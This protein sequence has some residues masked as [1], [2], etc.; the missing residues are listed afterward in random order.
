MNDMEEEFDPLEEDPA[1]GDE[2]LATDNTSGGKRTINQSGV[3]GGKV[4]VAPEDSLAPSDREDS[5]DEQML[6]SQYPLHLSI[7]VTKPN[8]GAVVIQAQ[9]QNGAID[10]AQLSYYS[11][12]ELV[13][14]KTPEQV[15]ESESVYTGPPFTSLDTDLQ[16]MVLQYLE[17]RGI[18]AEL[19]EILP[20]FVDFKEQREYVSLLD[21]KLITHL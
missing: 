8:L 20:Q 4:D 21:S 15:Q 16:A 17:E 1:F 14:P 12:A 10:I 6:D 9:A 3:K 18:N 11:K 2:D 19:A 7:T 5:Y 13:E